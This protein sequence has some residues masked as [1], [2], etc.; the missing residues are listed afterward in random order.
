MKAAS[1]VVRKTW[2]V[3]EYA[4][5]AEERKSKE[6]EEKAGGKKAKKKLNY[7]ELK[8]KDG[9]GGPQRDYL[10]AR[11]EDLD[12][13]GQVGQ[14][15]L[16]QGDGKT[17]SLEAGF[18]CDVCD[19]NFKDSLSYVSH[20]NGKRHQKMKGVSMVVE[21]STLTDVKSKFAQL[22]AQKDLD[23]AGKTRA[24][25]ERMKKRQLEWEKAEEEKKA[26]RR[27][28]KKQK[29]NNQTEDAEDLAEDEMLMKVMGFA[30]FGGKK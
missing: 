10:K 27:N 25:E 9:S 29:K 26:A 22:K 24:I 16:Q 11:E 21:R 7:P 17:V 19:M 3:N 15:T 30:G 1:N 23:D 28:A 13:E 2:D 18:Y 12:L 14:R 4:K 20:V 8:P 5:K 6:E